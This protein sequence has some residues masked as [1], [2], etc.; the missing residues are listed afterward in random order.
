MEPAVVNRE[1][2]QA[3]RYAQALPGL[4]L[5]LVALYDDGT[6]VPRANCGYKPDRWR[7]TFNVPFAHACRNCLRCYKGE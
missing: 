7:V 6:V 3:Y 4:K 5:H 1:T 2:H